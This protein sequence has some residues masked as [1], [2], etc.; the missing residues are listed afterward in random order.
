MLRFTGLYNS[1]SSVLRLHAPLSDVLGDLSASGG[2]SEQERRCAWT[3]H[4]AVS[5][6]KVP[7]QVLQAALEPLKSAV[8][9]KM[10]RAIRVL[11]WAV[12]ESPSLSDFG[13]SKNC[14]EKKRNVSTAEN[15]QGGLP[16]FLT[17]CSPV[18]TPPIGLNKRMLSFIC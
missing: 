16:P 9:G 14:Q 10:R 12:G 18:C 3:H 4:Q 6:L 2:L 15:A 17:H 13:F 11:A 5:K 1:V 8:K 7:L